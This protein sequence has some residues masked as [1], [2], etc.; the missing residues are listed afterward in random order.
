M[1]D[2]LLSIENLTIGF[3]SNQGTF[4]ATK[5]ISLEVSTG[6]SLG[7]VGESGSGKS[8]TALSVLNLLPPSATVLS[9][10]ISYR[11][12]KDY[13]VDIL[14]ADQ[15]LIRSI[16]GRHISMIFQEPMTSLNPVYTCGDQVSEIMIRHLD[17]S[18]KKAREKAE[19]L[20]REVELPHPGRIF[21]SYPHE[22]SGG[23]RQRV[24]IAMA[25]SCDP[26]LLIADEPTTALDVTIQNS[27]LV[28]LK[29]LKQRY[30][31]S[32]I[33]ISHDLAVVSEVADEMAVMYNGRI[34][35]QGTREQIIHS[36]VNAYTRGLIACKPPLN[37]RPERLYTLAD[38][39]EDERQDAAATIP[40]ENL[41]K[42]HPKDLAQ[43]P[44]P[45][46]TLH[47][48]S[49]AFP[50]ERNFFGKI[51]ESLPAIND[52]SLEIFQGET[53]GVVGES[54][55]GKSTLARILMK[56]LS[57]DQGSISF[58]GKDF[59]RFTRSD[60]RAFR[61]NVQII[62]QDPYS[63]L[64]PRLSAGKMISE[65]L[66][67]YGYYKNHQE[68]KQRT[69][70]LLNDVRLGGD[71]LNR[72]PHELSGGQR[73]RVAIARVLALNPNFIICDE[74]VSALDV[75]IQAEVLNL[76]QD[77]KKRYHL[78]YVFITHDFSVVRFM[79]DRVA[80]MKDGSII[81]IGE[82]H[83]V[84]DSPKNDY[85]RKLLSSIPAI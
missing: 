11:M 77:L 15:K 2:P 16:R 67:Y 36:P 29:G 44:A 52:V 26:D 63:T 50:L 55:S 76:L 80:V 20:F 30:G 42:E 3:P 1:N 54:G 31:M 23:Q 41:G 72:Y 47:N 49:K 81:E 40:A 74:A 12:E 58:K 6:R 53:L 32:L 75:S 46:F 39:M 13:W 69:L 79:S 34:V 59:T 73:Q 60:M 37:R 51:T 4:Y 64:N 56:L 78:T 27:I 82:S 48:V 7:I 5:E 10:K 25:I 85:T 57:F 28:L 35:E 71:F 66:Q 38:F 21:E 19:H 24:M 22:L 14:K 61:Q 43:E 8:I 70:E 18:H 83:R 62:F 9:G 45:I 33:F 84:F 65:P 17:Y 68:R